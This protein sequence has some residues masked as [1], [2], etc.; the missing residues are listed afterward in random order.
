M[1]YRMFVITL[2][3]IELV[4]LTFCFCE[5][6]SV[7]VNDDFAPLVIGNVWVYQTEYKIKWEVPESYNPSMLLNK[8]PSP[9]SEQMTE[10][11]NYSVET[12]GFYFLDNLVDPIISGY[13]MK[14]FIDE[15]LKY[16]NEIK[17]IEL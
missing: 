3:L 9:I 4:I 16:S 8:L 15:S 2:L 1:N 7:A 10:I 5:T 14:L 12:D 13:A 6:Y 11:Y 17:V